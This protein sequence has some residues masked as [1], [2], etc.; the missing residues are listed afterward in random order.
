MNK[1]YLEIFSCSIRV[2][3]QFSLFFWM[4]NLPISS[5]ETFTWTCITKDIGGTKPSPRCRHRTSMSGKF[6]II[7]GGATKDKELNDLYI[8]DTGTLVFIS[9]HLF[10]IFSR[11]PAMSS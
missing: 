3:I 11:D 2:T 8:L 9:V 1:K 7:F 4:L 6:L 10:P 5:P